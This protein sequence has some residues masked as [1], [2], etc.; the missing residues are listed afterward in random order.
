V[1][2]GRL[3]Q[4]LRIGA[5]LV[6][7]SLLPSAVLLAYTG[8]YMMVPRYSS[9]AE[10]ERLGFNLRLDLYLTDDEALD[11]GRY[12]TVISGGSYHSFTLQGWDWAHRARTSLY[13]ID[14]NRIAALS[15]FGYDYQITMK[16]FS[17]TP[18]V[19]DSGAGW[20]YLGAFDFIFR[21]GAKARLQ[22]LDDR[23]PECIPM[24]KGD[25]AG[26]TNKPRPQARQASCP[27]PPPSLGE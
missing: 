21:P 16:P 27:T 8:Y 14:D 7:I 24:G 4:S 13:R 2:T 18:V 20:Q 5:I 12:L 23:S 9:V 6:G 3:A 22:F 11:S 26:W 10:F 19:S 15:A 1:S 17:Y 25:P